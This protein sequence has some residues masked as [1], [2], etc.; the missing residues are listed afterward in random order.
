M[1]L[2]IV[3]VLAA[4]IVPRLMS[5]P[6]EARVVAARQGVAAIVSALNLYRLDNLQY[7]TV[8]QGLQALTQRPD[9]PPVPANYPAGGY[10][11]SPPIDPWGRPY[12]YELGADGLSVEV[13]SL[14]ADGRP[15][16]EGINAD[17]SSKGL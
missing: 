12:L 16:G 17:I 9:R 6:D 2:A 3:G 10:L 11:S 13:R 8:E 5:R 14:G 4:L 1:V 15:G 7:P